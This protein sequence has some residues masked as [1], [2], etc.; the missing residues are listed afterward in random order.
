MRRITVKS[1]LWLLLWLISGLVRPG[2]AA[3]VPTRR[4]VFIAGNLSHPA[5]S[6]EYLAGCLLLQKCLTGVPGLTTAVYAGGWPTATKDGRTADD[7]AA[8]DSADAIVM[9]SDGAN[10][11]SGA[12]RHPLLQDDRLRV[13]GRLMRKGAGLGLIHWSLEP[14]QEHGEKEFLD[15]VGGAF[16]VGWSVN[17]VWKADFP[18]LPDHPVTRGVEPFSLT[19]EWHFHFR[20][21]DG[22]PGV[23]PILVAIVPPNTLRKKDGLRS[24][25]PAVRAELARGEPQVLMWVTQRDDGGRGFGF[26]GGHSHL[27]WKNDNQRKLILNSILWI[28][29]AE[30]PIGGVASTVSDQDLL[31]NVDV[32]AVR[33]FAP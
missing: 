8:L 17:P 20:F 9:Y 1:R 21:Q 22:R 3:P 18:S 11:A 24:G 2:L 33:K 19:D 6:H 12:P 16:E 30:V 7:D 32:K 10:Y 14:T 23:T 29:H 28:A 5:L 25:N 27:A 26:G 4:V 31:A 15:W 13:M